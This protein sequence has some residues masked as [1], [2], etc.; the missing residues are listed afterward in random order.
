M[1]PLATGSSA[2][3]RSGWVTSR[4]L[5]EA[6]PSRSSGSSCAVRSMSSTS[7]NPPGRSVEM[8]LRS[9]KIFPPGA[10]GKIRSNDPIVPTRS[11]PS[12]STIETQPGQPTLL[13]DA[14][15]AGSSSTLTTS[16]SVRGPMPWTIQERPTPHPVPISRI[17]PPA[18]TALAR[19][20]IS[21]PTS[22]SEE[23]SKPRLL[24]RSCAAATDSGMSMTTT[25]SMAAQCRPRS[26]GV[27][28]TRHLAW[29]TPTSNARKNVVDGTIE[30]PD[31][32]RV[33]F[34]TFGRPDGTPVIW[35]HGGPGSRL[36]PIHRDSEVARAAVFGAPWPRGC[37]ER[38][39]RTDDLEPAT[40]STCR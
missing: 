3:T 25:V 34:A 38:Q 35:C 24:A 40:P 22:G 6:R 12:P 7:R 36:D 1:T 17:L 4:S 37:D 19:Q 15:I 10:S 20:A 8:V 32:R 2:H 29:G 5:T 31:G 11:A 39:G 13:V 26:P 27:P 28:S 9:L 21:C 14:A 30:L 23:S 18:G 16:T 33:G